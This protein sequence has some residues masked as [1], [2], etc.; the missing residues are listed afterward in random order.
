MIT[1]AACGQQAGPPP[2]GATT[3][4]TASGLATSGQPTSSAPTG[5]A[6]TT[7]A[8]SSPSGPAGSS[9]PKA[10]KTPAGGQTCSALAGDLTVDQ[11]VGQLFMVATSSS[12]MGSSEADEL[13]SLDVGS[14]LLLENS[15]AGRS[16]IRSV[17]DAIRD[18]I[19]GQHGVKL[20]LAADQEGGE[21]QR[22][23]GPGFDTIPSAEDQASLSDS[24]LKS[25]AKTW[26]RQ[27]KEAGIDVNLAP[28]SDVVPSS[29]GTAN[30]PIGALRRGYGP[31]AAVV[32]RKNTAFIKGMEAAG[33]ATS[34]KHFPGLGIVR[35][36][37]DTSTDVT[38][39]VT[40]R[41]D[42]RLAGF[43]A[44]VAA[45]VDMVMVSSAVYTKI[46]PDHPATFSSTVQK[47]MIRGD[48][49]FK[50]VIISDDLLGAALSS[51]PVSQRAL[52]F[53]RAGGDL[54]IVGKYA[55]ATSMIKT[56]RD[57]AADDPDLRADIK[58][59]ATRVLIM[60]ARHGLADCTG[61]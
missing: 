20:M 11:Q 35:G 41:D 46:D 33:V 57:A 40:T 48:L 29:I 28:V 12:G 5:G 22:L 30:A 53:I 44:G 10:S 37:T 54:S 36:N 26:G 50:G 27:L 56:V 24:Q 25:D 55:D 1:L 52:R 61:S 2:A 19:G 59:A 4:G 39:D 3:T 8:A 6:T 17:T 42:K 13:S 15:T 49:G 21:V 14:V 32:A 58:D 45:G 60:K 16:A 51:E 31:K 47:G 23:A 43:K 7:A 9:S 38:D 18:G 34:V